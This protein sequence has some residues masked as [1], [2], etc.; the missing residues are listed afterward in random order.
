MPR[1]MHTCP[2]VHVT[3]CLLVV[4]LLATT[5]QGRAASP[6]VPLPAD[7]MAWWTGNT[8]AEDASINHEH[9]VLQ[10]GAQAGVP[11]F[12]GGAFYFDGVTGV[13]NTPALLPQQGT[14]EL[15]V[16]P[17]ALS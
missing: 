10:P 1:T 13:A 17:G 7:V 9:A 14:V 4:C 12:V 16:K 2:M 6:C 8:D 15:W 3:A 5:R 11:A